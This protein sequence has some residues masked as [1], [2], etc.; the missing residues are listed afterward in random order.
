VEALV[1][2]RNNKQLLQ[3]DD[4]MP[5]NGSIVLK[6]SAPAGYSGFTYFNSFEMSAS[7]IP[8]PACIVVPCL[9]AMAL[10]RRRAH[11]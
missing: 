2:S 4:V 3:I 11:R 9:A 1:N 7:P 8:E 10:G 6:L 5:L